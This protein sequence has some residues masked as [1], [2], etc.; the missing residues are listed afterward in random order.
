MVRAIV[1]GLVSGI[2]SGLAIVWQ[3]L[4]KSR[5]NVKE[6]RQIATQA[7]TKAKELENKASQID[8][9]TQQVIGL[10]DAY[11]H[12]LA[13]Y[14]E[15]KLDRDA[16]RAE[17]TVLKA[18]M[19]QVKTELESSQAENAVLR[20]ELEA[21]RLEVTAVR[22]EL[23]AVRA[24]FSATLAINEDLTRQLATKNGATVMKRAKSI[25]S[26]A[27]PGGADAAGGSSSEDGRV[28]KP[29]TGDKVENK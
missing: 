21:S 10:Q 29:A 16:D 27:E 1:T 15:V 2:F 5:Q 19:A 25:D 22:D 18:A 26:L 17:L 6:A 20:S 3:A 9:N 7:E 8:E 24:Q 11:K 23:E 28:I 4:R 13:L 14:Q 12:L